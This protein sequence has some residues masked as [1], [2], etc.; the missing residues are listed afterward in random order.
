MEW[1]QNETV[2]SWILGL[3]STG[4]LHVFH[5]DSLELHPQDKNAGQLK[6]L[7]MT[8]IIQQMCAFPE[9]WRVNGGLS[10][11]NVRV[12]SFVTL[13]CNIFDLSKK[14]VL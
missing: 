3:V 7:Q 1:K 13:L 2:L 12:A 4:A 5:Q 11:A 9:K 14:H 6:T 8:Y 10:I